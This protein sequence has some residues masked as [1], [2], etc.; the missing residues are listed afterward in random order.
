MRQSE[1]I[2]KLAAA[3]VK[4]QAE[5]ENATKDS[6][7]PHFKSGYASLASVIDTTKPVLSK[8][9]LA[10]VQMP[11]FADGLATL[12]CRLVHESGE[13]IEGTAGAPLQKNDPQGV[14]SALTYLRRYS[15]AALTGITQEDDDGNAASSNGNGG[16]VK[17][18]F[19]TDGQIADL[20]AL[21]EEVGADEKK[22][23]QFLHVPTL[24]RLQ[25]IEYPKAVQALER[26]REGVAK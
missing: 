20:R 11:G 6:R 22:F 17:L 23:L 13:W 26:K 10:V 21:M 25:K 3:L 9:G 2:A 4:A 7:N 15:L 8:Y 16:Y 14:G 12:D 18:E 1:S 19:I 24:D 5:V